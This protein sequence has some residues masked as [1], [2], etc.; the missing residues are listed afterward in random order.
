MSAPEATLLA[1][2]H[3]EINIISPKA[4]PTS[5]EVLV[6]SDNRIGIVQGLNLASITTADKISVV[7]GG[8]VR[9]PKASAKVCAAG[10]RP[11]W[12]VSGNT[13]LPAADG[14]REDGVDA[15]VGTVI[16]GGANGQTFVD[17]DLNAVSGTLYDAG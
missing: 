10:S 12:D 11:F 15:E 7:V 13:V 4:A 1:G 5:G 3:R 16:G 14:G 17:V 9:L 8:P 2:T 6:L